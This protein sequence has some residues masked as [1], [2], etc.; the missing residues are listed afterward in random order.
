MRTLRS[1]AFFVALCRALLAAHA[2][3]DA[4]L[5]PDRDLE[6]WLSG[7]VEVKPFADSTAKKRAFVNRF[8]T[9]LEL[10]Y[11]SNENLGAGKSSY[12]TLGLRYRFAK[13]V[14]F[15]VDARYN[16]RDRFNANS[17]RIDGGPTFLAEVKRFDLAYR[18]TY[19]H[20]FIRPWRVRTFLR[21]RLSVAYRTK[22]FPIDPYV[23]CETFTALVYSGD[24]FAGIRYDVG[25]KWN[26]KGDHAIDFA[27]RHDREINTPFPL[28]RTILVLAYEFGLN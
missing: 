11:R 28:Y 14:R 17:F 7:A 4:G 24:Y 3:N 25:G 21:N 12:G 18:I 27:L 10:G 5:R 23:S 19:Q 15:G 8:V 2:Q 6:L 22:G 26:L 13:W 9:A 20:E 1:I 16:L